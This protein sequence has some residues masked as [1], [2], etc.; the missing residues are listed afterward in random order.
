MVCYNFFYCIRYKDIQNAKPSEL[1]KW[2]LDNAG[3]S[4]EERK[5]KEKEIINKRREKSND[6]IFKEVSVNTVILILMFA[7]SFAFAY[8]F[9]IP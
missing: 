2:K 9:I 8:I 3:L 6:D 4:P 7:A 5:A 1:E